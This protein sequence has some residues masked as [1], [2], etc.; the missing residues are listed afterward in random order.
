MALATAT[1]AAISKR[2]AL[3]ILGLLTL[4]AP[5]KAAEQVYI[6]RDPS[7]VVRFTAIQQPEPSAAESTAEPL[8]VCG[9][10]DHATW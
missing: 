8:A 6:W 9:A 2:T 7:G 1:A 4:S 3:A 5:A 10:S